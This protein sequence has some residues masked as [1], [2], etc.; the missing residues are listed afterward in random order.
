MSSGPRRALGAGAAA[1]F[2]LA[3]FGGCSLILDFSEIQDAGPS[4]DGGNLCEAF[5]PNNEVNEAAAIGTDEIS[6]AI[7]IADPLDVDY[8]QFEAPGAQD[9]TVVLSMTDGTGPRS[10]GL[11]VLD[12]FGAVVGESDTFMTEE[13]V[14]GTALTAGT[15]VVEVSG[16]APGN[17]NEYRLSV[18]FSSP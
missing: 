18:T 2:V 10:L 5:E 16:T 7:C 15:Y 12:N 1:A 11:R 3:S 8:Y 4:D 17:S 13:T 9:V 14:V 6:A